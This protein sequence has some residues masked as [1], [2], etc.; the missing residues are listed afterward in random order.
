MTSAFIS[1]A[2]E[3]EKLA[4]GLYNAMTM[5]G[6]E[7]FLAGISINGGESWSDV[8]LKNLDSSNW[9]FFLAS[10]NS[11]N[12][13]AVQQELGAALIQKKTIIS[14]L[15]DIKPEE[16]P[17]WMKSFQAIDINKSPELLHSAISHISEQIKVD[18]FWAG[19]IVGAIIVGLIILVN[20]S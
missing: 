1:Y 12:S 9:V 20:K 17:A 3:D 7:T 2:S 4:R 11:I 5:A 15:I 18:K 8:I 6:I 14:L 19:I 10:K 13:Q 16:L